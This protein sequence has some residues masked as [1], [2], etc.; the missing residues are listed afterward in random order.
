[1]PYLLINL[2]FLSVRKQLMYH[3]KCQRSLS[4]TEETYNADGHIYTGG[5]QTQSDMLG[6]TNSGRLGS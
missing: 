4:I 6:T 1:M 2:R 5:Y 3:N